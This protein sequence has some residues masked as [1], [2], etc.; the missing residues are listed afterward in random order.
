MFHPS[1]ALMLACIGAQ[2]ESGAPSTHSQRIV[3]LVQESPV[4]PTAAV[5]ADHPLASQ[6]GLEVLKAGGN[7]VDAAVASSFALSVVRP[8]SCGI[9]G[10]GFMVVFLREHPRMAQL[11][12]G[13]SDVVTT[14]IN[15]R[16]TAIAAMGP[17]YFEKD[18][19]PDAP[20]RG[21]KAVAIPGHVAGML[22]ALEKYGTLTR[23]QVLAPAI[24]Y[25]EQGYIADAHYEQS[26]QEIIEWINA[27]PG[28][29]ERFE[30]LWERLLKKGAIKAG[31]RIELP[32]QG[33]VLRAIAAEGLRGF[34]AG[35]VADAIV[36]AARSDGG[37]ITLD[38]LRSYKVEERPP[39]VTTFRGDT[40]LS[41]PPP[42]SGGI[43]LAQVLGMLE[44]RERDFSRI[45]KQH[46]HNS[47]PYIHVVTEASKH[48]FA[49]RARW[50]GD[51]NFVDV[52]VASLLS[53]AYIAD[54]AE[55]ILLDRTQPEDHY[56][57]SDLVPEDHGT[58]HLCVVDR[59]GNA[60]G[61]SETINLVF[62]SLVAVDGY[63]FI[64]NDTV[65]DF[66]TRTGR[67]NAFGLDHAALNRPTP[68]KRP[69]S[70]MTPTIV[71]SEPRDLSKPALNGPIRKVGELSKDAKP[72]FLAGGSGGPRIISGTIQATLNALVFDMDPVDALSRPRFHH[73]WH[74]HVLQLEKGLISLPV[75]TEL[76][77]K[78]GHE[79]GPRDPVAAVQ[80]IKAVDGG[81]A[82]ASDP[83][84]GGAPAGY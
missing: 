17:E 31:D 14:C 7:A 77:D 3:P 26:S 38:D 52:P 28:R 54:R 22:H 37:E 6:A 56:G 8:Y 5:A 64:L 36:R 24:R 32:E 19:D 66:L 21:G 73:Q 2:P 1:F 55:S 62:G 25:A 18:Q 83:R 43:V 34:Y 61:C 13:K 65:D 29:A 16:E 20:T 75:A 42:S 10:G 35:P 51:P 60:V 30:F 47:A 40:V 76:K 59:W 23:E 81:W 41:M 82:P 84:K 79:V 58:S 33:K 68:G 80:I 78:Y 39:L 63:G 50:M 71:I 48:A 69:L 57:T 67:P 70:S 49:D 53:P 72:K 12:G 4:F 9:G 27:A 15:Y 44:A 74:P 46:G 45:V 11:T